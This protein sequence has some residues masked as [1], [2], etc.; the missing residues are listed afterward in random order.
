MHATEKV[1]ED[2]QELVVRD[3]KSEYWM[4]GG[5]GV[6]SLHIMVKI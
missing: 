2:E 1:D 6:L 3:E 5:G 4:N